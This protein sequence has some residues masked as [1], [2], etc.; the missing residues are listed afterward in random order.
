VEWSHDL[1][2]ISEKIL[3]RRLSVFAGGWTLEA[4]EAICEGGEINHGDILDLLTRL[5]DKSLILAEPCGEGMRHRMLETIREYAQGQVQASGELEELQ[6]HHM[7]FY[8]R[9]VQNSLKGL[10]GS[11]PS[12]WFKLLD[13]EKDN[14]YEALSWA[15]QSNEQ[16]GNAAGEM[17]GDLWMWWLERGM[18]SEGRQWYQKVLEKSQK[19]GSP[20]AKALLGMATLAWTQGDTLEVS[21][22]LD[23]S[24][25]ILRA[26][27]NPDLPD[28]AQATHIQGHIALD[29]G[30]YPEAS[31]AFQ[32]S[33]EL[34][35]KLDDPYWVG[36]LNSDLGVVAY[37][38]G[39][40]LPGNTRKRAWR[41]SRNRG[42]LK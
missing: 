24:L 35:R 10:T 25:A 40:Y 19:R 26:L 3:F 37:H 33:L 5:M 23:E 20:R 11:D 41:C 7:G 32:E 14:L 28:L 18:L 31:Q 17:A 15:N 2:S 12:T 4:A 8:A 21:N 29:K 22:S 34:Y 16:D 27:E 30:N 9:L 36:T 38:L 13:S 39:D 1:L 6:R 42:I